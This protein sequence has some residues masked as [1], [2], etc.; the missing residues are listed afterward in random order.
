MRAA[1][2]VEA[3]PVADGAGDMLDAVEAL[4]MD[5]LLFQGPDQ[6]FDHAVL[7]RT[8]RR[9][10]KMRPLSDLSR[11]SRVTLPKVPNRLIN[12][13]SSALAAV[14]ALPDRDRCQPRSSRVWQSIT[15]AGVVQPSRPAQTLAYNIRRTVIIR[16]AGR[17]G[18]G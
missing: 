17:P 16:G 2:V 15:R 1:M 12:A 3:D 14:V 11:N 13:C 10:V 4:A 18:R 5:A 9:D 6:A 8:V 7:L